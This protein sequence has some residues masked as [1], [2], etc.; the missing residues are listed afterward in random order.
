[1][2]PNKHWGPKMKNAQNDMGSPKK[3]IQKFSAE[4]PF[5]QMV[6]VVVGGGGGPPSDIATTA[7]RGTQSIFELP[8]CFQILMNVTLIPV[9]MVARVVMVSTCTRVLVRQ[10]TLE[11]PVTVQ[12]GLRFSVLSVFICH[13]VSVCMVCVTVYAC[14]CV[15]VCLGACILSACQYGGWYK[16]YV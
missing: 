7:V 11:P 3:C 9:R 14:V 13:C 12:V 15:S 2:F 1:M 4:T 10:D 6:V 16:T 8:S 5:A